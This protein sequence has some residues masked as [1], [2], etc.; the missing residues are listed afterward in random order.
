MA[1]AR[2][3]PILLGSA[4]KAGPSSNREWAGK[5]L[6]SGGAPSGNPPAADLVVVMVHDGGAGVWGYAAGRRAVAG[7]PSH[8][9]ISAAPIGKRGEVRPVDPGHVG[10]KAC[11]VELR[12]VRQ[13]RRSVF[14]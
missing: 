4:A 6:W 2:E 9:A 10:G 12:R 13:G 8:A 14:C 5:P 11:R 1:T 7:G 3:P